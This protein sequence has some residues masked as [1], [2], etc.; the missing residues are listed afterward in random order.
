MRY[1]DKQIM[2][3]GAHDIV[4]LLGQGYPVDPADVSAVS[5]LDEQF[6]H[7]HAMAW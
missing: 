7:S 2:L 5:E 3:P 4:H 6:L 1:P